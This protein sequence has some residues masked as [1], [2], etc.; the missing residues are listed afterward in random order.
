MTPRAADVTLIAFYLPQ[1]HPIPENDR[2]W[3][4]GF[5]EWRNVVRAQP[6]FAHHYQPHAPGELGCY[7]LREPAARARQAA[8]ARE[9]GVAAFC[10]YHYWFSGRRLL[11][12]PLADGARERNAGRAAG[13]RDDGSRG[14]GRRDSSTP[15]SATKTPP[16]SSCANAL[17][18]ARRWLDVWRAEARRAGHPDL[19]VA[20]CKASISRLEIR[21]PGASTPAWNFHRIG[22]DPMP[23]PNSSTTGARRF[24][25]KFSTTCRARKTCSRDRRRDTRS[26]A[27]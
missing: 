13:C 24:A 7:D 25:V 9:H 18:D 11:E 8:L 12:R 20:A 19:Y 16:D 4:E 15:R 27:A 10:Y 1:Y 17:R 23:S 22:R 6:S 2:W 3:G 21:A 14:R 26:S 5:T